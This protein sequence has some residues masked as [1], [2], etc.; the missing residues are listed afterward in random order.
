MTPSSPSCHTSRRTFTK[1]TSCLPA[2][3]LELS[4]LAKEIV[5]AASPRSVISAVDHTH[6]REKAE[7]V[8]DAFVSVVISLNAYAKLSSVLPLPRVLLL[9]LG[10]H[11]TPPVAATVL[12]LLG[13]CLRGNSSF[14]RKF[15]LVSGWAVLKMVLPR[16]WDMSVHTATFNVLLGRGDIDTQEPAGASSSV[17]C[18]QIVP[19]IFASLRRGLEEIAAPGEH[20]RG[21]TTPKFIDS[22][23]RKVC[24]YGCRLL[25]NHL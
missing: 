7:L 8:F 20:A 9:L 1:V 23:S 2:C 19:A 4:N 11:P 24:P 15:E 10:E 22:Q 16:A 3:S 6:R 13:F 18:P 21:S 25:T 5:Q 14:S 12:R 17:V